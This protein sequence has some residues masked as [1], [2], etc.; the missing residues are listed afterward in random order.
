MTNVSNTPTSKSRNPVSK[1]R[2]RAPRVV[3][4]IDFTTKDLYN[5]IRFARKICEDSIR[6]SD[7]IN[8][9]L[10]KT[11]IH[12]KNKYDLQRDL[13][14]TLRLTADELEHLAVRF[15]ARANRSFDD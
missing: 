8:L 13:R 10:R 15:R 4:E 12:L 5:S 9:R 7:R 1:K 11:N 14:S 2:D 6:T 3:F